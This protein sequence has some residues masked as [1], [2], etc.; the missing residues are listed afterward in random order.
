VVPVP[1]GIAT[2]FEPFSFLYFGDAQ[3]AVKS[4]FSRTI[5]QAA[6]DLPDARLMVFAGDLVNLR[7]GSHDDEW[8]EWFDAGGWLH[9]MMPSAPGAR[10]PRVRGRRGRGGAGMAVLSPHWPG[11]SSRLPANGPAGMEGTC[12]PWTTRGCASS[13]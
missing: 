11:P 5:R 4:H 8:G 7:E 13:R 2:A 12:T 9:G 3:N 1:H 6:L 10:E